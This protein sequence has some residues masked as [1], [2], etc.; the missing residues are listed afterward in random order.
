[1]TLGE[2]IEYCAKQKHI[3]LRQLAQESSINYNTLYSFVKRGG[4]KLPS[5]SIIRLS[6]ALGMKPEELTGDELPPSSPSDAEIT[7]GLTISSIVGNRIGKEREDVLYLINSF[8]EKDG[9]L[10]NSIY[11]KLSKEDDNV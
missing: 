2:K 10:I 8:L 6:E 9:S 5:D 3:S 11:K 7:L 4:K 1:M